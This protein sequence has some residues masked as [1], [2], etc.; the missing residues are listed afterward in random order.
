MGSPYENYMEIALFAALIGTIILTRDYKHL[1][2]SDK[3]NTMLLIPLCTIVLPVMFKI[4]IIVPKI[5]V[6]PHVIM[7]VII[8]LSIS[9]PL[10]PSPVIHKIKTT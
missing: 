7:I 6:L 2:N 10:M 3:K 8:L 5:L 9:M 4:P 1:F